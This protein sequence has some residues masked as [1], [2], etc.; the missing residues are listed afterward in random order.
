MNI[1]LD[2]RQSSQA[3]SAGSPINRHRALAVVLLLATIG[4]VNCSG[5]APSPLPTPAAPDQGAIARSA[6]PVILLNPSSGYAGSYINVQGRGWQPSTVVSIKLADERGRSPVLTIITTDAQGKFSTGFLY[7]PSE[8]WLQPGGRT[9]I[10]STENESLEAVASFAVTPPEGVEIPT[11][12]PG[13]TATLPAEALTQ[14]S[15]TPT[16]A[17]TLTR[18]LMPVIARTGVSATPANLV[19]DIDI[20]PR[21]G[22]EN[23]LVTVRGSGL[24]SNSEARIYLTEPVHANGPGEGRHLYIEIHSDATGAYSA[25]F[26][27]PA[28]WPDGAALS[29]GEL[30]FVVTNA[31]QA[32]LASAPFVF[33]A[34]SSPAASM[35]TPADAPTSQRTPDVEVDIDIKPE[36]VNLRSNGEMQ[37]MVRAQNKTQEDDNDRAEPSDAFELA[38]IESGSVRF[39]R[40]SDILQGTGGAGAV[41]DEMHKQDRRFRFRIQETG[42]GAEDDEACLHGRW[43]D[44]QGNV[45]TFFGCASIRVRGDRRS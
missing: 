22:G 2:N 27:V 40:R 7:P 1:F 32:V 13:L 25:G 26:T 11:P 16:R 19:V 31:E 44:N 9:V 5:R 18:T 14:A 45:R 42:L 20:E 30:Y 3:N 15:V 12:A 37:V 38:K 36:R 34:A 8:R 21:T 24:A 23:T 28:A 6:A 41:K 33:V 29:P 4:L 39:G 43:F 35:S 10:A 17:S